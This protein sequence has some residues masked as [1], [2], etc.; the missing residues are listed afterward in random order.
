M[1]GSFVSTS[2]VSSSSLSIIK[3]PQKKS[4]VSLSDL[5]KMGIDEKTDDEK[6][7]RL[8]SDKKNRFFENLSF[9]RAEYIFRERKERERRASSPGGAFVKSEFFSRPS[10]LSLSSLFASLKQRSSKER[11]KDFSNPPLHK[12]LN[13]ICDT[14]NIHGEKCGEILLLFGL[15][16][17]KR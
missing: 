8:F 17:R 16:Q 1:Q 12:T 11:E 9:S 10:S 6:S 4:L 13:I 7:F 15:P 5:E 3:P 14:L 2:S